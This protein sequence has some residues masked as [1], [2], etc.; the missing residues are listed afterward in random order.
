MKKINNL[1]KLNYE[2][3]YNMVSIVQENDNQ[4]LDVVVLSI[5]DAK[6]LAF[7][8]SQTIRTLKALKKI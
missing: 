2:E 6:T 4:T 8:I 7:E 5:E 1:T 3:G